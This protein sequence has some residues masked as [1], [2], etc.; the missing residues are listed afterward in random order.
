MKPPTLEEFQLMVETLCATHTVEEAK[1]LFLVG[2]LGSH[3]LKDYLHWAVFRK[4]DAHMN[5][6]I[7]EWLHTP[8]NDYLKQG[9]DFERISESTKQTDQ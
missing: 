4:V 1:A 5:Y 3:T 9:D 6:P 7:E 2:S 8:Y